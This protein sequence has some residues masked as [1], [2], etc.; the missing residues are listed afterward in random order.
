MYQINTDTYEYYV[1]KH[2]LVLDKIDFKIKEN[3]LLRNSHYVR[4]NA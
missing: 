3:A 2:I 1:E 4:R